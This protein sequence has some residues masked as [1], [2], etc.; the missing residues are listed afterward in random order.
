[1]E[2]VAWHGI[3]VPAR[4]PQAIV[5]RH[6]I[7]RTTFVWQDDGLMQIIH[8][9]MTVALTVEDDAGDAGGLAIVTVKLTDGR[10][11]ERQS[12]KVRGTPP[13]EARAGVP[14]SAMKSTPSCRARSPAVIPAASS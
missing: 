3:F 2:A 6:E 13:A 1:M 10:T 7:L 11:F 12:V 5:D 4:T 8:P 14:T 9:S